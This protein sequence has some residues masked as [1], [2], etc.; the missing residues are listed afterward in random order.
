[1]SYYYVIVDNAN[2]ILA[3]IDNA[4]SSP[5]LGE[6][7]IHKSNA[8]YIQSIQFLSL[9]LIY[10]SGRTGGANTTSG[11]PYIRNLLRTEKPVH[12]C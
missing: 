6:G 12:L 8:L 5:V 4:L 7:S 9:V 10:A 3:N 2:I 1:M 11:I